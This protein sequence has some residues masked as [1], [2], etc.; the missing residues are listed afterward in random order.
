MNKWKEI[1]RKVFFPSPLFT[2]LFALPS[3]LLVFYVLKHEIHDWISYVAYAYSFYALLI[4][5]TGTKRLFFAWKKFLKQLPLIQKLL[6]SRFWN[7]LVSD[8]LF[9]SELTLHGG[10]IASFLF[11]LLQIYSA[12]QYSS[13]W[14]MVQAG[15][16][17][18]LVVMRSMLVVYVHEHEIT[19]DI[20]DEYHMY[21]RV[22]IL[23]LFMNQAL[24]VMVL[25]MVY[26]NAGAVYSGNMIYVMAIYAFY[27]T[28]LSIINTIR[29]HKKNTTPVLSCAKIISLT[30]ALVSMLSLET[31]MLNAFNERGIVFRRTMTAV[32]GGCI[33]T[34]VLVMAIFMIVRST[35]VLKGETI[36]E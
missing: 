5:I 28:T 26:Q 15:Y 19:K 17:I 21:R 8:V 34:F 11:A 1:L 7:A 36:N 27:M 18:L 4:S 32:F 25:Y 14:S 23:L 9:R 29:F 12:F 6:K 20:Y 30:S 3:F 33:C 2:V 31:A 35:K 10:L 24:A 16:Y 13:T 22:G